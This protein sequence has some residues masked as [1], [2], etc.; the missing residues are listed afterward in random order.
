MDIFIMVI[1][2]AS[3][4]LVTCLAVSNNLRA[5]KLGK[6]LIGIVLLCVTVAN[7]IIGLVIFWCVVGY[8][9]CFFA[10]CCITSTVRVVSHLGTPPKPPASR[11]QVSP[12]DDLVE[13]LK[14]KL[15]RV[16]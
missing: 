5:S 4:V 12:D 3:I 16:K 10:A 15:V 14:P 2:L 6:L 13:A 8:Y 7:P 9:L 1:V 11:A